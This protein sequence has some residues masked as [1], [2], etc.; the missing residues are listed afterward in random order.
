MEILQ[1]V[2]AS[3]SRYTAPDSRMGY[4]IPNFRIAYDTLLKQEMADSAYIR[5]QLAGQVIKVFPNPFTTRLNIYYRSTSSE[6]VHLQ[7]IDGIG[8]ITRNWN[9]AHYGSYGYFTWETGLERLPAGIYYLRMI[10]GNTR[11][12]VKL[13]KW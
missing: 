4:G 8:R 13:M 2:K 12:V 7:L 3:S 5:E 9:A 1:A 6:T 10:Q 11:Q